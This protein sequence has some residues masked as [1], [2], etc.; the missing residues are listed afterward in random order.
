MPWL[1]L[2]LRGVEALCC[3]SGRGLGCLGLLLHISYVEIVLDGLSLSVW[4]GMV[5]CS[6]V[7]VF[8]CLVFMMGRRCCGTMNLR[9]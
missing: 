6:G 5:F 8:G 9:V 3:L 7:V 4:A 2:G 1:V